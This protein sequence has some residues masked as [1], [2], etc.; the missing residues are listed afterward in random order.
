MAIQQI[1]G[2]RI[3]KVDK[4]HPNYNPESKKE[5]QTSGN[6]IEPDEN[7]YGEKHTYIPKLNGN[8]Q[9]EQMM[10]KLMGKL[11]NFGT[12]SQTGIKPVEVDIKREL[13][14]GKIDVNAVKSQE[15]KGK[16]K[17]KKNQLKALRHKR[18]HQK[19]I[20]NK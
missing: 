6:V 2:K 3:I 1:F 17:N 18:L 13:S 12:N 14:I 4:S 10:G 16:V 19:Q 20:G 9:M 15:T 11:D 5:K 8:L 7:I